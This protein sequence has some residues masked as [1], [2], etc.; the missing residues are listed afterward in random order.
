VQIAI[1]G[2]GIAGL[3]TAVALDRAGLTSRVYE[4]APE[5]SEVGAG[6]QLAPNAV[7]LLYRLG[8][9]EALDRVTV[10]PGAIE[11]RRWDDGQ[12]IMSTPLGG[13]AER[14]DAPYLTVH[15]AHLH[16]CLVDALPAGTVRL[17]SRLRALRER[18]GDVE[19]AFD[20][21]HTA[22]AEVVVGA[23]G[24]RSRVRD[25]LV[26]DHPRFSGQTI[27]RGLVPAAKL[28]ELAAD[29][30]VRLWLGPDQHCVS[31]P[32]AG[33]AW[34]SF[35]ATTPADG[36]R[37]ESWTATGQVPD[38]LQAYRDWHPQ[39]TA[40]LSAAGPV[41]RWALHDR[42]TI[43]RWSTDRLTLVGDAAHP[44]L[45]FLAQGANQAVEDAAVLTECL[46]LA[47]GDVAGA[48]R[49]YQEIRLPRTTEVH[50]RSRGNSRA[51]H[52]RD[53]D[54]QRVRDTELGRQADLSTQD[55]LYGY[56]ATT[57]VTS[58]PPAGGR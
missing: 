14:Y 18:T 28:P 34:I 20:D 29:P 46:S 21:G 6:L 7:R 1:I 11:M 52:L 12:L 15:R 23:D 37:T 27:Y 22:Q 8:L 17:N 10:R 48:L 53:G 35:G 43:D 33:G 38:M 49:R 39:V 9:G 47:D 50:Q 58:R 24:I 45:P 16:Q 32:V 55:W 13:C 54:A 5:L 19:L 26:L 44:M 30:K 40:L 2:A 3:T 51:L 42:D 36:W 56:D 57:A 25:R 4:Q 31:Y 41:R